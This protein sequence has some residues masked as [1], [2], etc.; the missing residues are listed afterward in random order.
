ML[1]VGINVCFIDKKFI[2]A[3]DKYV[4]CP[5]FIDTYSF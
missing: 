2:F 3:D 5:K 1:F 4:K